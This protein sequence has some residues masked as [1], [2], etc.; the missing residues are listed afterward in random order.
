MSNFPPSA[1]TLQAIRRLG[2]F[3]QGRYDIWGLAGSHLAASRA[4]VLSDLLGYRVP[5]SKAG[6][7]ALRTAFYNAL[8]IVGECEAEREE[9]F[10][11]VCRELAASIA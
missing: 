11:F 7:T 10:R 5:Q 1:Q 9:N 6:V 2:A 8:G 4:I 3:T